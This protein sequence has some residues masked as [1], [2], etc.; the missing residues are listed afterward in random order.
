MWCVCGLIFPGHTNYAIKVAAFRLRLLARLKLIKAYLT[1]EGFYAMFQLHYA[2]F[3]LH[4]IM[5]AAIL[6]YR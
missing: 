2:M 1:I 4:Y 3:Q 6:E 5:S